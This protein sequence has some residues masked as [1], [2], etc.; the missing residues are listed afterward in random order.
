MNSRP[1]LRQ[2]DLISD[3]FL[4]HLRV[5]KGL[6]KNSVEAYARDL[7][8]FFSY[9]E[10]K[11]LSPL[12]AS[13]ADLMDFISH[14]A[15]RLSVRS[16]ARNISAL[17]GF[18]RF[19]I[20]EG[21]ME[22]NPARLLSAPKLPRRL[23]GVLSRR[24][25]ERLLTQP[26]AATTRGERDKAMLELLYATGL[27]VSELVHL[28]IPNVN[29]EAGFVR[30]LG[31]GSKERMV[32]IGAKALEALRS[33][34]EHGRPGLLKRRSS[35]DLFLSPRGKAMT[36]QGFWKIIKRYGLK[37]GI[38]KELTPHSL[39]HSFAS[40]LLECGADLRSVQIMLGHSDIST[41]QIYTH[42]TRERLKEIHRKYHPR[43]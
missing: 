5:E 9:L 22:A 7:M 39:R 21:E 32:P 40:H 14:L 35:S 12:L 15:G 24:E 16:I 13:Q 23:P 11:A 1:E 43:P 41:T 20:S 36:R 25:V 42:V 29:M 27:R 19:L 33:Y 31:K 8:T 30:T 10:K 2:T 18:Y 4:H 26:D 38:R 37:A 6:A 34:L 28:K 3:Q 17:K